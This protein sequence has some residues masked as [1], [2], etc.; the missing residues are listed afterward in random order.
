MGLCCSK[1]IANALNGDVVFLPNDDERTSV[2]VKI[3]VKLF[4]RNRSNSGGS[5][6]SI[7]H[8]SEF[9]NYKKSGIGQDLVTARELNKHMRYEN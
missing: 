7:S 8:L 3:K 1:I 9:H 4:E 6:P 2:L 5:N